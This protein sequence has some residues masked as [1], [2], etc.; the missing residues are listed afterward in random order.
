MSVRESVHECEREMW[1][2]LQ[3]PSHIIKLLDQCTAYE[4]GW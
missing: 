3:L 4:E 2:N 1:F